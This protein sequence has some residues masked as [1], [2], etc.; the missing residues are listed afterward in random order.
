MQRGGGLANIIC[1]DNESGIKRK[2]AEKLG[3]GVHGQGTRERGG[4]A[5]AADVV[6]VRNGV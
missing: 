3:I 1:G 5:D 6:V 2:V 4:D